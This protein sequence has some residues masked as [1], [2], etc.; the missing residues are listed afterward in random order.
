LREIQPTRFGKLAIFPL[1]LSWAAFLLVLLSASCCYSADVV[2]VRSPGGSSAE[3]QQLETATHFY[4]LNLIVVVTNSANNEL[5]LTRAVERQETVGVAIA[6]DALAAVHK[7]SLLRSLQRRQGNSLPVLILGVAPGVDTNL[8]TSW[9]GG[10]VSGCSRLDSLVSPQYVFGRVDGFTGQLTNLEIPLAVKDVFYLQPGENGAA[11]SITSVRHGQLDSPVFIETTVQQRKIFVACATPSEQGLKD[12][13]GVVDAFL[14]IAPAMMFI[15]YCGG[16]QGWH[17]L[18]QYANLTID[19]PWLRKQSYG[20]VD[21]QGL[22]EEMQRHNF[23]T[24]IAFIPWNYDRSDPG[25]V[26]LF[27]DHP[28]RFSITVHGDNHDH[29]EFT[30]YRSKP[31]AVQIADLK[32]SLARMEKFR[33]LTGIPYD[34]VM[35]F[36][37][38]I[39][40]EGTLGALKA[41]NFLATANSTNVPQDAAWPTDLSFA[42]R[43]VTLSFGG[44]P[45]ISRYSVATSV[46]KSYIAINE[47]L[48]NPLLFY[49]HSE[50]FAKGLSAFDGAA[51]EVNQLEPDTK[52]RGLGDVVKHLYL[53]K[54]RDDSNY[55]VLAFSSNLCLDNS[56]GRDAIYF[57]RKQ[58]I[59]GQTINSV[60]VDGQNFQYQLH[61]DYLNFSV[62]VQAR[63]TRCAA[64]DYQNDLE[65][66]SIGTSKNSVVVY[67]LRMASD[68]RDNYVSKSTFGLAFIR[69]YN[70]HEVKP[71]QVLAFAFGLMLICLFASYRLLGFI[72]RKHTVLPA[73]QHMDR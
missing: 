45:S 51:D 46:P 32:Q 5:A 71:A 6:A 69:F 53:T 62:P 73:V 60:T 56:T 31:L 72:T 36:P 11:Q 54:L 12:G 39:A 44:F 16:E 20:Y 43:P 70:E 34:Q 65:L 41:Y 48:G 49:G 59:G 13:Q 52:W 2:F 55:D 50:D 61:D 19:D 22:L 58:E 10:A 67:F 27:R 24:T 3:Q 40:P 63:K 9:T 8:L 15:K 18:H 64:I 25:V 37:H 21:Y 23:H 17:A 33:A 47:F 66:A 7:D 14:Q 26:S 68:F 28:D 57:V 1:R 38:S 30:D 29:K 42:L 4:G 35:V